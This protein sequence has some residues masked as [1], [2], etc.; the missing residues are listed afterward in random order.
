[1]TDFV[2][3]RPSRNDEG[4]S[5]VAA[6]ATVV[7]AFARLI[8][9]ERDIEGHS[10]Q[11]PAVMAWIRDAETARGDVLDA[12]SAVFEHEV[13]Q[14]DTAPVLL[15]LTFQIQLA[16]LTEAPSEALSLGRWAERAQA[17]DLFPL[18]TSGQVLALVDRAIDLLKAFMAL[19]VDGWPEAGGPFAA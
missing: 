2:D 6:F 5:L 8:D 4:P 3:T 13:G 9:A 17:V 16:L 11:D 15:G 7:S 10:G 19:E 14:D 1:M 12:I 18:G